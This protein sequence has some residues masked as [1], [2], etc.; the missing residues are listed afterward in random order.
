MLKLDVVFSMLT[1]TNKPP[2]L[3]DLQSYVDCVLQH[4]GCI[5][6]GR[7]V[8]F[9]ELAL[10][11]PITGLFDSLAEANYLELGWWPVDCGR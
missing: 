2:A 10:Y 5:L 11:L 7:I 9:M 4:V 3:L 6:S 8:F 1:G